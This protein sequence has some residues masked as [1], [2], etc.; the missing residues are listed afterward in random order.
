MVIMEGFGN[1]NVEPFYLLKGPVYPG[2]SQT[3]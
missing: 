1:I 2:E 3:S